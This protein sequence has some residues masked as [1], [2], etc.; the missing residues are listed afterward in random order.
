MT[1]PL[2]EAS[3]PH[4]IAR[5]RQRVTRLERRTPPTGTSPGG[6]FEFRMSAD[7]TL[8]DGVISELSDNFDTLH[9]NTADD[10]DYTITRSTDGSDWPCITPNSADPTPSGWL[11]GARVLIESGTVPM[12]AVMYVSHAYGPSFP[13]WGRWESGDVSGAPQLAQTSMIII[14]GP[15][16]PNAQDE[17]MIQVKAAEKSGVGLKILASRSAEQKSVIWGM[18]VF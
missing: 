2:A 11:I 1:R 5:I 12:T 7:V 13:A 18:R 10:A 3:D 17:Y 8:T 9:Y 14:P 6:Y 16:D 15:A 4:Q